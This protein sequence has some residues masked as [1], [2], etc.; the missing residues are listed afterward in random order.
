VTNNN[1]GIAVPGDF[2][3]TVNGI[4]LVGGNTF[5]GSSL[6]VTRSVVSFGSYSVTEANS[7]GYTNSF[8]ADC[9][10]TI[11]PGE[12]KVCTV[13]NDDILQQIIFV[14]LP[15]VFL[16]VPQVF[17]GPAPVV[18]PQPIAQV[19]PLNVVQ[20]APQP[21]VSEI[22]SFRPPLS[23]SAGLADTSSSGSHWLWLGMLAGLAGGVG[24]F[25]VTQR[26]RRAKNS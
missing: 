18:A 26:R 14:P 16:P 2:T 5:S 8:S 9:S 11:A 4:A 7:N 15:P 20:P 21:L 3:L 10:S 13:T 17:V 12:T 24:L 25:L 6:G 19:S 1:T 22:Q 23:G